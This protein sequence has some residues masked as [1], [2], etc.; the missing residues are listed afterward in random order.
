VM[1]SVIFN[2]TVL[3]KV[4]Q[5]PNISV[6][7]QWDAS[8]MQRIINSHKNWRLASGKFTMTLHQH[9]LLSLCGHFLVKHSIPQVKWPLYL[10]DAV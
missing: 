6:Y 10:P 1:L 4:K 5:L 8:V 9:I 3:H 2:Y 7:K